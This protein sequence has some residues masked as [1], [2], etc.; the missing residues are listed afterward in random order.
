MS[1]PHLSAEYDPHWECAECQQYLL[2]TLHY[3]M[4]RDHLWEEKVG[5]VELWDV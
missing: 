5:A 3:Y 1:A 2:Y 4:L